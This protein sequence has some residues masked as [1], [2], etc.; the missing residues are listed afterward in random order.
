[1]S[2]AGTIGIFLGRR[3]SQRTFN[4]DREVEDPGVAEAVNLSADRRVVK[5]IPTGR[6]CTLGSV[7]MGLFLSPPILAKGGKSLTAK[8]HVRICLASKQFIGHGSILGIELP[9]SV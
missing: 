9:L 2:V 6:H 5:E 8:P 7:L 4:D 3:H 1:L